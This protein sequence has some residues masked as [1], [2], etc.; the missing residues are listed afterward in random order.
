MYE[1]GLVLLYFYGLENLNDLKDVLTSLYM[2]EKILYVSLKARSIQIIGIILNLFKK[3][4]T[5]L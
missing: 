4:I 2:Q 5:L 3:N 1:Y